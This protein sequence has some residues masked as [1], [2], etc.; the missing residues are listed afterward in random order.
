MSLRLI[1]HKPFF[2][3]RAYV[4]REMSHLCPAEYLIHFQTLNGAFFTLKA[5]K[6]SWKDLL[7]L[8]LLLQ[9]VSEVQ[10][11]F[12]EHEGIQ[13]EAMRPLRRNKVIVIH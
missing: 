13:K 7:L 5:F 12:V 9:G 3:L 8:S 1:K 10:W 4:A 6:W 2:L 11:C